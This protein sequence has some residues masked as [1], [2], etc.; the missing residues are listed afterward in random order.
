MSIVNPGHAII[1]NNP[2]VVAQYP[3][4]SCHINGSV[5][6]VFVTVRDAVHKGA[7]I[8]SHPLS[9]SIKPNESPYKSVV[10]TTATGKLDMQSLNIIEDAIATLAR[11][12]NRNRSYDESVLEDFRIIDLD[13]IK[14]VYPCH[15]H[16]TS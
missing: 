13:L 15:N 10:I 5:R 9:G 7:R 3:T 2:A 14:G 6:D 12:P 4:E 11:M 1:T 8:I 16:T